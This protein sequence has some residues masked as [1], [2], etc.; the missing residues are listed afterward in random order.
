MKKI[1]ESV[2]QRG[3]IILVC[4]VLILGWGAISVIQMQRDY[5]PGINNTT[6]MV[7]LRIFP[8]GSDQTRY[9]DAIGGCNPQDGWFNQYRDNLV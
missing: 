3:T 9:Y 1:I 7:S 2:I 8:S 4:V 5:L 6:L